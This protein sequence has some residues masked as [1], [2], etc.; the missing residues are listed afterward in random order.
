MAWRK[1]DPSLGNDPAY[2]EPRITDLENNKLNVSEIGLTVATL[3]IDGK[4]P[5]AQLPP[6]DSG[7]VKSVN[8]KL[9]DSSGNV[10][11]PTFSGDYADLS[12]KPVI[13]STSTAVG[14][15]NVDNVKQMPIAGGMFTGIATAHPNTSYTVA[16]LRNVVFSTSDPVGG[17]N[18]DIWIKYV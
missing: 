2:L 16:Q 1:N 18:G 6:I 4:V 8:N 9:P 15:G 13:P 11:I 12:N 3:D 10:V 7:G 14:L 17:S 5:L